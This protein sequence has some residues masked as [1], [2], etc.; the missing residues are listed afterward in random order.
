MSYSCCY[1]T[2][3][4][5]RA[6]AEHPEKFTIDNLAQYADGLDSN[7]LVLWGFIAAIGQAMLYSN[8][9]P[10]AWDKDNLFGI[11]EGLTTVSDLAQG[12]CKT[13]DTLRYEI[14]KRKALAESIAE[15]AK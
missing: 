9:N 3:Y 8:D 6:A 5:A 15:G 2:I 14:G 12:I 11:G 4:K 10:N 13:I 1:E 7:N